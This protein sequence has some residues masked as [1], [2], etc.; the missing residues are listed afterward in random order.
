MA[1]ATSSE[2]M[3]SVVSNSTIGFEVAMP[4]PGQF[5]TRHFLVSGSAIAT[6]GADDFVCDLLS[7]GATNIDFFQFVLP[8]HI[9]QG[10][11]V[12]LGLAFKTARW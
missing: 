1:L 6:A 11:F 12:T 4:S 5:P 3:I 9:I 8:S 7:S 10:Y 2:R